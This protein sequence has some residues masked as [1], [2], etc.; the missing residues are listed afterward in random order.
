MPFRQLNPGAPM[1]RAVLTDKKASTRNPPF[2]N[3]TPSIWPFLPL[4]NFLY[5]S[6]FVTL[7]GLFLRARTLIKV[8]DISNLLEGQLEVGITNFHDGL[9]GVV[10]RLYSAVAKRM[11]STLWGSYQ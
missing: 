10:F 2:R 3:P 11:A 4:R 8:L 7:T 5:I 1:Q 9:T 6:L